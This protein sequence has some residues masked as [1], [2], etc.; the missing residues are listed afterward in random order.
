MLVIDGQE[1]AEPEVVIGIDLSLTGPGLAVIRRPWPGSDAGPIAQ[2]AVA[3]RVPVEER[4]RG[5]VLKRAA[6]RIV[7]DCLQLTGAS[8]ARIACMESLL[9]QSGTG[10]APER[11][12]FWWMVRAE[13]ESAGFVV[14]RLD[15]NTR[16]SL[17]HD[18]IATSEI[19]A[20]RAELK[21]RKPTMTPKQIASASGQISRLGKK[22]GVQSQQRRWPRVSFRDDNA[23]DALVCAEVVAQALGWGGFPDLGKRRNKT[24]SGAIGALGIERKE[25]R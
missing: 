22:L 7:K 25:T 14:V 15:P 3:A 11:A 20:A 23:A 10:K 19:S 2:T 5:L 4:Q 12:A 6:R 21:A 9:L 24:M 1:I 17:A 18:D 13:L 8:A 16:R